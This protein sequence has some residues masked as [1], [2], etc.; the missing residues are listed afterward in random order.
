MLT[1][2]LKYLLT[3]DLFYLL[4]S[5]EPASRIRPKTINFRVINIKDNIFSMHFKKDFL[6]FVK[7]RLLPKYTLFRKKGMH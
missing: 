3:I 1:I 2:I 5:E 6:F 4:V 7:K